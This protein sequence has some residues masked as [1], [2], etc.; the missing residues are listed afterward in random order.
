MMEIIMEKLN[1]PM[2][3]LAPILEPYT[4][5]YKQNG[6]NIKEVRRVCHSIVEK[7]LVKFKAGKFT[8]SDAVFATYFAEL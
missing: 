4:A 1:N 3:F 2:S 5:I 7:Q 6:H 8:D